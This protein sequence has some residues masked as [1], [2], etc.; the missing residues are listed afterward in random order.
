MAHRSVL[1]DVVVIG[2]GVAGTTLAGG[3]ARSGQSIALIDTHAG[4]PHD[5]RAE[6]FGAKV[7]AIFEKLG[8]GPTIR[9]CT[10]VSDEVRVLRFGRLAEVK[11]IREYY[12]YYPNLVNALRADLPDTLPLTIGRVCDLE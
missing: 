11:Q 5:F 12:A 1:F 10:S 3:L 9:A 2:A 8:W 4:N 7:M 6:K